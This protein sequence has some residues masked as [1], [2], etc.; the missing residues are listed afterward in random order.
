M[1]ILQGDL[2]DDVTAALDAAGVPYALVVSRTTTT[3]GDPWDPGSGETTTTDYACSG[4][5]DSYGLDL[6]DGTIIQSGDVRVIILQS[7]IAIDPAPADT[8]TIDGQTYT[9][10]SVKA[11]P[12]GTLWDVQARA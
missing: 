4:W 5:L 10:I 3:G 11:D 12:A 6:I 8:V 9:I 2:A 7:S 1:S